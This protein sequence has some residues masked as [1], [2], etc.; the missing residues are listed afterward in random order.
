MRG[1]SLCL[2]LIVIIAVLTSLVF[3]FQLIHAQNINAFSDSGDGGIFSGMFLSSVSEKIGS[4]AT[5]IMQALTGTAKG[6]SEPGN[7]GEFAAPVAKAAASKGNDI[8][9]SNAKESR[10]SGIILSAPQSFTTCDISPDSEMAGITA[11]HTSK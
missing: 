11:R 5:E 2:I 8:E 4:F 10:L 7:A 3:S 1:F 6:E 9:W